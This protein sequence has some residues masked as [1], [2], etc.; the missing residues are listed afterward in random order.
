MKKKAEIESLW[1]QV[2]QLRTEN[3]RLKE[4]LRVSTPKS[5]ESILMDCDFQLPQKV[6]DQLEIMMEGTKQSGP[7]NNALRSF[8]ITNAT[9][10]DGP[11]VFA[12]P[13]FVK[14]TGYAM[15]SI[16]GHNCR[17]LQ[18]PDT[19]RNEVRSPSSHIYLSILFPRCYLRIGSSLNI[20]NIFQ[21]S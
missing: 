19:D 9:A 7:D 20:K 17:F 1:A 14:L 15:H 11:I 3:E 12:S 18:G 5:T 6:A 13:D 16:L 10:P 21:Y 8:L 2:S 4:S